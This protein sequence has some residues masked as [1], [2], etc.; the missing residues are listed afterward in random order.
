MRIFCSYPYKL[1][2][3]EI[4]VN[5]AGVIQCLYA[6]CYDLRY[7]ILTNPPYHVISYSQSGRKR[8]DKW[9]QTRSFKTDLFSF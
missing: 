9:S 8:N 5:K 3:N 1:V 4:E 7:D 6:L 2:L